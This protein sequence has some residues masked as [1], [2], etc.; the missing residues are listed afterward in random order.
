MAYPV[1]TSN[2]EKPHAYMYYTPIVHLGF[3]QG[4]V[5]TCIYI[6]MGRTVAMLSD[7]IVEIFLGFRQ[8]KNQSAKYAFVNMSVF[9]MPSRQSVGNDFD[10]AKLR[11]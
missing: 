11:N 10:E 1:K 2:D 6:P 8:V 9:F 3:R 5:R 7:R 4:A